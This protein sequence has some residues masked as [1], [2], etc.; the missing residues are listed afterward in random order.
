[1]THSCNQQ[2]EALYWAYVDSRGVDGAEICQ[3][4]QKLEQLLQELPWKKQNEIQC[5]VNELCATVER[6]AFL[7]GLRSGAKLML[8][9]M[10]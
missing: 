9:L 6:T 10:E 2:M 4:Y 1:M 5:A 7:D 8:E 3:C